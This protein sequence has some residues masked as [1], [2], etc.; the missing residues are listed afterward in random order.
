M[1]SGH[2]P[3]QCSQARAGLEESRGPRDDFVEST[4]SDHL[5]RYGPGAS[6]GQTLVRWSATSQVPL[7]LLIDESDTLAGDSLIAVLR[8]RR[9]RIQHQ[10]RAVY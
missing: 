7:V 10:G 3:M 1:W 2:D 9:Q 5:E 4:M 8:R 6:V